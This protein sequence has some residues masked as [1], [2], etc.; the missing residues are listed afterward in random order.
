M[1]KKWRKRSP[2]SSRSR[3]TFARPVEV[4]LAGDDRDHQPVARVVGLG[5]RPDRLVELLER[6]GVGRDE[7]DVVEP[8][9]VARLARPRR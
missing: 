2:N 7:R 4:G 9:R 3:A 1:W 8:A 6:L 5:Q